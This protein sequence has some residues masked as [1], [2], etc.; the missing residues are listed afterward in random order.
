MMPAR[1]VDVAVLEFF[2]GGVADVYHF[3]IEVQR[4]AGQGVV[5]V[6]SYVVALHVNDTDHVRAPVG[7]G[8]ELHAGGDV[9]VAEAVA[10]H[11][12]DE[13]LISNAVPVLRGDADVEG[14]A[15]RLAFESALEAGDDAAD[16]VEIGERGLTFGGIQH[17]AAGVGQG[18]INRDDFLV[19]NLHGVRPF[20]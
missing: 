5:A 3:D 8:A 14:F 7:F 11:V 16:A 9:D 18:V 1:A 12:L 19:S 17:G 10:R 4:L 6:H 15:G 20:L 13:R 2:G